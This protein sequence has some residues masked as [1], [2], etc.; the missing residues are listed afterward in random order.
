MERIFPVFSRTSV[1]EELYL[2]LPGIKIVNIR[3]VYS[4]M[5]MLELSTL[6]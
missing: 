3:H 1:N 2:Y 4:A 6:F 5:Y